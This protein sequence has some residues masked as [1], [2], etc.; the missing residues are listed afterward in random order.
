MKTIRLKKIEI[1]IILKWPDDIR[2]GKNEYG[3][4]ERQG[5]KFRAGL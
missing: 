1:W 2:K 4:L 5:I 3:E